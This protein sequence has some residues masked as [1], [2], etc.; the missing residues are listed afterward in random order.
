MPQEDAPPPSAP[1]PRRPVRLPSAETA[2]PV[3]P[4]AAPAPRSPASP[5]A[6]KS[7]P[8]HPL[9][10]APAQPHVRNLL[11]EGLP[12]RQMS[13]DEENEDD[14]GDDDDSELITVIK[15]L[16]YHLLCFLLNLGCF[17]F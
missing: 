7:P 3:S 17:S 16:C 6:Q 15:L 13:D 14:W 9:P 5:P 2:P 1:E 10:A 8:S 4:P 12:P 11:Q